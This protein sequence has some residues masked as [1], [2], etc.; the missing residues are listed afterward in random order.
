MQSFLCFT[1]ESSQSNLDL[2]DFHVTLGF[3]GTNLI[4]ATVVLT[5]PLPSCLDE[6]NWRSQW[7]MDDLLNGN[8]LYNKSNYFRVFGQKRMLIAI[9]FLKP[10]C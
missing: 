1:R 8:I 2:L 6:I 4:I 10:C 3:A 7:E 9:V 5:I